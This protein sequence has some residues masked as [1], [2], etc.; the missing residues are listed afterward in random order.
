MLYETNIR[1]VLHT[2]TKM[3]DFES[4]SSYG[5]ELHAIFRGVYFGIFFERFPRAQFL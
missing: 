3:C 2:A 1:G 4:K 5:R